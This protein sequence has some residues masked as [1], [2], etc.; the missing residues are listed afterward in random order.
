MTD[1]DLRLVPGVAAFLDRGVYTSLPPSPPAAL[2]SQRIV[3][4]GDAPRGA[5]AAARLKGCGCRKVSVRDGCELACAAGTERLE[6]I[7]VRCRD[8]GRLE[9]LNADVV[10]VL[11]DTIE[12]NH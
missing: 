11:S 7:V 2:A 6:A 4:I 12:E 5:D 3:V 8:S 1:R 10:F 9:G